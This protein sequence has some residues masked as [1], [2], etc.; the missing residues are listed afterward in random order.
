MKQRTHKLFAAVLRENRTEEQGLV[1]F[2]GKD[3]GGFIGY[4]FGS[5]YDA[6]GCMT[7]GTYLYCYNTPLMYEYSDVDLIDR[8][9]GDK[10]YLY[11][12]DD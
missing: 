8:E 3:Q 4:W 10:I 11:R 5:R 1:D 7:R 6:K 2:D 12:L 9:N